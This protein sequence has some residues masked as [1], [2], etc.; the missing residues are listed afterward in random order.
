[1]AVPVIN[2]IKF[3]YAVSLNAFNSGSS[4]S[5]SNNNEKFMTCSRFKMN[6][7][8]TAYGVTAYYLTSLLIQASLSQL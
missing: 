7:N 6:V 4:G 8:L 5:S 2:L 3:E 1:V